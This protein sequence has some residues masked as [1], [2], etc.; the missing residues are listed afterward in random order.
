[1]ITK[2]SKE[3]DKGFRL[4]KEQSI[5]KT[6]KEAASTRKGSRTATL[7]YMEIKTEG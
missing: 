6:E 2:Q 5:A 4:A 3:D 7:P 1:M